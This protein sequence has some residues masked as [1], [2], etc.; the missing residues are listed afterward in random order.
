M[1]KKLSLLFLGLLLTGTLIMLAWYR[2]DG[3]PI[4]ETETFMSGDGF[5]SIEE[6]D[7]SLLFVPE[8]SNGH[9][10]LIMHGALILPRSYAK[11]AAYFSARG[12]TVYL[13]HGPG[14]MSIAAVDTAADR[15]NEIEVEAW[16][17]IGHSMG[18]MAS[19]AVITEHD[20]NAK[21]V[22]LWATAMPQDYSGVDTPIFFIW[23][24]SDGILPRKRFELAKYNLPQS[25]T[26]ITLEGA[27]HKNF[28]MYSHQ[29][30]DTDA[31]IDWMEQIDF[32]NE[33]TADFFLALH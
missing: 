28:S 18:G 31:S 6:E 1:V 33:T 3:I 17:F 19:L 24:D 2:I 27:N 21:G 32:A 5:T 20:V 29:F 12:Y 9:G 16:F 13:P 10:L 15:L 4:K 30:F 26:Y 14:R 25:V 22:A 8:T 23:G 7:G 11:S